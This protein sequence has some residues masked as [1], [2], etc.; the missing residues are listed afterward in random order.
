M[1][2]YNILRVI[3]SNVLFIIFHMRFTMESNDKISNLGKGRRISY[4]I[5]TKKYLAK[6]R[7]TR[8]FIQKNAY[9]F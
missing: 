7:V 6:K 5:P 2:Y 3:K 9:F 1:Q 4:E 8:F